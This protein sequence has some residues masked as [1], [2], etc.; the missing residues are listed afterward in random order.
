MAGRLTGR[1]AIVTGAAQGIGAAISRRFAAEGAVVVGI[2]QQAGLLSELAQQIATITPYAANVTDQ[3]TLER[4]VY[5]TISEHKRID[6]L[7][8]N[9]GMQY[10]VP[11]LESTLA[12][13]QHT[14]QVN[15]EAQYLLCKL[16]APHMI[17][18]NYGRIVNISSTQSIAAEANVTA[19]AASKGGVGAFTRSLAVDLAAH[20]ILVNAIAPGAIHTP[21]SIVNGVDELLSEEFLE[22]YVRRRKIPLGRP[23][24]ADEIANVA[25]FLA[26]EEC[27]YITGHTLVADG[28]LT[29]TF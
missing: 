24:H 22:W 23:G 28:G 4:C 29:I 15:L 21:M 20:G 2:D 3:A 12:E 1:I 5:Q 13:W 16:V 14:Q 11:F 26:S 27:S 19:Y 18:N 10:T 6:I 7:V 9:A 8:N 17:E 25:L